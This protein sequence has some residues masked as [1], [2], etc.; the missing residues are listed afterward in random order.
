MN[1]FL[2]AATAAASLAFG[3]QAADIYVSLATGK[4]KNAGTKEAPLKNLWKALEKA[5]TGDVIHLAEGSYPGKMKCGWFMMTRPVSI[6]GG[7]SADFATR[8][9]LAHRTLFQPANENND[10][11]GAGLGILHI[12]FEKSPAKAPKGFKMKLDGLIFDDGFAS[13]Y[14]AV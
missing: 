11:K 4:N 2:L 12:E 1:K 3:A 9:P 8:D 6:I 7:Y 10:K 14:H 13:S 5:E